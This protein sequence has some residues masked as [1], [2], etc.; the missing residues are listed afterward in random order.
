MENGSFSLA[1]VSFPLGAQTGVENGCLRSGCGRELG[2]H[3]NFSGASSDFAMIGSLPPPREFRACPTHK[4]FVEFGISDFNHLSQRQ[5]R[6]ESI[7]RYEAHQTSLPLT[8]GI[9]VKRWSQENPQHS[10]PRHLSSDSK[11]NYQIQKCR[12]R[13][14][15]SAPPLRTWLPA[16]TPSTCTREYVASITQTNYRT[17]EKRRERRERT[18]RR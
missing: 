12:Q 9:S 7:R 3:V 15:L 13:S 8:Y 16:S 17:A 18:Q 4:D 2:H 6:E 1:L 10:Q 14:L 11:T 5:D